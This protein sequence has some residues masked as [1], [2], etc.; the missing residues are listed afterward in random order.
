MSMVEEI[1]DTLNEVHDKLC[2]LKF[3]FGVARMVFSIIALVINKEAHD[4][5]CGLRFTLN[6]VR[7]VFDIITSGMMFDTIKLDVMTEHTYTA[8]AEGVQGVRSRLTKH[9]QQHQGCLSQQHSD[10]PE[11]FEL[12][13]KAAQVCSKGMHAAETQG[14][15]HIKIDFKSNV[16]IKVDGLES[17]WQQTH[18]SGPGPGYGNI[19]G[20]GW[21]VLN[22]G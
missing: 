19:Q 9:Q 13:G 16:K 20:S 2:S 11:H 14:V 1:K 22:N 21:C 18:V 7:M 15:Q 6:V 8:K 12:R 5:L 4:K 17:A 3:T 10:S